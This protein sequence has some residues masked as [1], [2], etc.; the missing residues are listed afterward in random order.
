MVTVAGMEDG[1]DVLRS[2]QLPKKVTLVGS[3]GN[4]YT[5]LAKPKDDLRKDSRMMEVAGVLNRLFAAD[6]AARRRDLYLRRFAVVPLT[7]DCGIVQWVP[8]TVGL[9][10]CIQ[11]VYAAEGLFDPHTTNSGI[12]AMYDAAAQSRSKADLL[13]RVLALFPPRLHRWVLAK[14]P[15]PA[16]WLAARTAFSRTA[17][18]W[19][20]V[21]HVVGE[22]C[23]GVSGWSEGGLLLWG[24]VVGTAENPPCAIRTRWWRRGGAPPRACRLHRGPRRPSPGLGDRHG[25]NIL[26]DQASGDVVHVDFSCLFDKGLTLEKPEMVPFR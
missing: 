21:G 7:E 1:I 26:I 11:D 24:G 5:F 2:L 12:K 17:A 8:H 19:S 25:E 13:T 20:M 4:R 14:F 3:D 23:G 15:E 18:V 16:A 6:A 9:R 10:H 22:A